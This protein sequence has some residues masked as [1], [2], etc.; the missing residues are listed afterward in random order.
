M[1]A[2][3]PHTNAY[4]LSHHARLASAAREFKI[5]GGRHDYVVLTYMILNPPSSIKLRNSRCLPSS[6]QGLNRY[7]S[8][9]GSGCQ[10]C[11]LQSPRHETSSDRLGRGTVIRTGD[12]GWR[13]M[14]DCRGIASWKAPFDT[15]ES[16]L[17]THLRYRN[18]RKSSCTPT[19]ARSTHC[20]SCR[21]LSGAMPYAY[22]RPAP[23]IQ[24]N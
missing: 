14:A 15:L 16:R 24:G 22:N 3:W 10:N 11:K 4:P 2:N 17:M 9:C 19:V 21:P 7:V 13:L 20:P 5:K 6:T 23:V 12:I 8:F 18:R 1:A